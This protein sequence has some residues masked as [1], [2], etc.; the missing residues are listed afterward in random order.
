MGMQRMRTRPE[1]VVQILV[2]TYNVVLWTKWLYNG[3]ISVTSKALNNNL[4]ER[5]QN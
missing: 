2:I 5:R 1:Y 3:L 4:Q